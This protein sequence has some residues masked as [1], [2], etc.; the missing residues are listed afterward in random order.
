MSLRPPQRVA[1]LAAAIIAAAVAPLASSASVV[2]IPVLVVPGP[3]GCSPDGVAL[4]YVV[5]FPPGTSRATAAAEVA[6]SCGAIAA[7]YPEIGVAVTT[8]TDPVF[9]DRVGPDRAYSA[10][11]EALAESEAPSGDGIRVARTSDPRVMTPTDRTGE[12]WDMSLIRAPEA[13]EVAPGNHD[14]LVGVLDSGIDPTHPDLVAAWI[15]V[16]PRVACPVEQTARPPHGCPPAR[17]TAPT[18]RAR[19]RRPTTAGASPGSLPGRGSRR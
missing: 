5:L 19:S 6:A 9:E 16:A 3:S 11:S 8:S 1:A 15:R 12:Q 13:R 7:Y 10:E 2:P 4:R 18:S 14:V 17:S